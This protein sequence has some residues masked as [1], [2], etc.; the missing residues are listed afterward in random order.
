MAAK[1]PENHTC[2]YFDTLCRTQKGESVASL[3]QATY[4]ATGD[5]PVQR[6]EDIARRLEYAYELYKGTSGTYSGSSKQFSSQYTIGH[7]LCIWKNSKLELTELALKVAKHQITIR[8]Y[9]DI[10]FLNYIQPV[11]GN[12]VHILYHLL[13]YMQKHGL[14]SVTKDQ[15]A[16]AYMEVGH[17]TDKGE[18]N[19][20]YNMLIASNYFKA[21]A[22][23]KE[24]LYSAHVSI[25]ELMSRCDITY[26]E[27]GYEVAKIEL[28]NEEDYINYITKDYRVL[29]TIGLDE[30]DA[31]RIEGGYNKLFYGVPGS[32]KS[33][34]IGELCSDETRMERVVFHPDYSYSDFVGQ[35]LPRVRSD[36]KMEY[37]FVEGPFTKILKKAI[38]NPGKMYFLVIEEINRG[39]A[40]AIFG[41]IFQLLDRVDED[42]KKKHTYKKIGESEYGIT[43]YDIASYVYEGN[44][45]K[46]VVIPS[47][48]SVVATM[49]TS[50][51]N[52]FTLDTAFQRRWQ[53][54]HIPNSFDNEHAKDVIEKSKVSWG[55]FAL[56]VNDTVL[57]ISRDFVGGEDK[58][59]GAYFAKRNELKVEQFPEKVLKYL[60]D[61]AF[62]MERDKIFAKDMTSLEQVIES[63]E[64]AESDPLKAV[65][66][67][68]VYYKMLNRVQEKDAVDEST[69]SEE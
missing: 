33:Y 66:R 2:L 43:N 55:D 44:A 36:K 63:Y 49:N 40:P 25:P 58:R 38:Y 9:F 56:V 45:D 12:I 14:R 34:A 31:D 41:E 19:G 61:D 62:K 21:D 3:I 16:E 39:N 10:V 46:L 22:S 47:N 11:N 5:N 23:G 42:S 15:M 26:V 6:K 57:E 54:K 1:F 59:L 7:E 64:N 37:V 67:E 8:D 24:L 48:L 13:Q 51:Q 65:L 27:K 50:D 52:V 53:M 4:F 32:G 29:S 60:W 18:I 17:A 68:S 20:A 35:I 69:N 28:A 30:L